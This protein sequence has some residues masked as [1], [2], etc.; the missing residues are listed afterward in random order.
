MTT[1]GISFDETT[2]FKIG[3]ENAYIVFDGNDNIVIGGENV[4]INSSVSVGGNKT[5]S[6]VLNDLDQ[7]ITSIEYGQGNSNIDHSD[8]ED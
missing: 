7:T 3:D 5:L 6:Q 1:D 8:I 4:E 2:P